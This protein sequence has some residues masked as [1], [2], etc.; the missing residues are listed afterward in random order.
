M[1]LP[2]AA[3]LFGRKSLNQLVRDRLVAEEEWKVWEYR[4]P[5]KPAEVVRRLN[6]GDSIHWGRLAA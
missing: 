1:R 4:E 2:A 6:Y 5:V 3:T